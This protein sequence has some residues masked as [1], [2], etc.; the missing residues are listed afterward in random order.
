MRATSTRSVKQLHIISYF[1]FCISS[2]VTNVQL[3][4]NV[5]DEYTTVED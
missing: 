3:N 1:N 2:Q 5:T 4:N